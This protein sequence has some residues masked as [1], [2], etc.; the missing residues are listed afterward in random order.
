MGT[1]NDPSTEWSGLWEVLGCKWT[2]HILR[3]LAREEAR[4][5]QIKDRIEGLPA[6]T[7]ST[8]LKSLQS[9]DVVRR[10]VGDGS[11]PTV[12]YSLTGKGEKLADIIAEIERLERRYD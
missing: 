4:F 3:L 7:L 12:T 1:T 9:E 10:E 8:R 5:N 11:P 2:F 6:S